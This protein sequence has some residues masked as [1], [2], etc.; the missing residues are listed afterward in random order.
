MFAADKASLSFTFSRSLLKLMST[1]SVM[2]SDHLILCIPFPS[3][4]KSF[5]ASGSFLMSQLLASDGQSIGASCS[6][7][8]LP[9]IIQGWFPL[10]RTDLI[11][12]QF[13]GLL[14]VFSNTAVQKH[15]F[16]GIQIS[17]WS[18]SHIHTWLLEKPQLWLDG[19]WLLWHNGF[20]TPGFYEGH[21]Y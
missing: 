10:E 5:P 21:H 2:P 13:K 14:R 3:Y 9:K 19:S 18:S 4:L 6:A 16:F 11:S 1:K 7:S 8:V 15:Q 20:L 17:L 12:L